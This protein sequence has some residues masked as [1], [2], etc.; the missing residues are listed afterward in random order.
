MVFV[1]V[2]LTLLNMTVSTCNHVAANGITFFWLNN[3]LLYIYIFIHSFVSGHLSDFHILAIINNA[4][5]DTG[6]HISFQIIIFFLWIYA[7]TWFKLRSDLTLK[8]KFCTGHQFIPPKRILSSEAE[9]TAVKFLEPLKLSS[10]SFMKYH[11]SPFNY[12]SL[13]SSPFIQYKWK[14]FLFNLLVFRF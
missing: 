8:L 12:R 7:R 2:W 5:M 13:S 9:L 4:A 1:L 10:S 14:W 6:V 11:G 3:I